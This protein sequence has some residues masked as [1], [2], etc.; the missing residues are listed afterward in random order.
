MSRFI[1]D[2]K[3]STIV[4]KVMLMWIGS[5]FG[6][7]VKFLADN[8]GE[9]ANEEY[10]DM[11]AN[12]N[13]EV[14]NTAAESPWQ[15]GLCE[16]NHAVVDECLQ[17]VLEENPKM[18]PDVALVWA[19]HA[20]NCLQMNSGYSSYQ[21][22]FGQNPNLPSVIVDMPPALEGTTTS[23]R[24]Y[25]HLNSLHSGRRAFIKAESSERIRRALRHQLRSHSEIFEVGDAVYYKRESSNKWKG[26]GKVI[27]QDGKTIFVPMEVFM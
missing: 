26:P 8:G 9:F 17:K 15:N 7:P 5:G 3:P 22:L 21:L 4:D 6:C 12:L 24:F 11:C 19:I 16:R 10:K 18:K 20:K 1:N 13:I 14:R 2:K 25:Q 27:G 23:E